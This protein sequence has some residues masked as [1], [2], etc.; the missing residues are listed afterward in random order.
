MSTPSPENVPPASSSQLHPALEV[1]FS[2]SAAMD[3]LARRPRFLVPILVMTAISL[4]FTAVA[5][6]K[7]LIEQMLR[8]SMESSSRMERVPAEQREQI[9]EN[10]VR[11]SGYT[12][13]ITGAA[14]STIVV[15][16]ASGVL[17]LLVKMLGAR[18]SFRQMSAVVAHAWLPVSMS[19]LV[20]IPIMLAKDPETVDFR[21]VVPMANLGF[22]FSPTE[23]AKLYGAATSLDLFSAWVIALMAIGI[24]RVAGKT[25]MAALFLILPAWLLYVLIFKVLLG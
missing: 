25:K 21:N 14:A 4:G 1:F 16:A 24:S 8:R 3:S 5:N 13:W 6:Q 2:P 17:L 11:W 9:I 19:Q 15:L 12:T 20:G 18:T 10:A 7:G 23:Q 22:L